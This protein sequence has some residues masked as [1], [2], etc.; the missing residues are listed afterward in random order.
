[1]GIKVR[2]D[3]LEK[4]GILAFGEVYRGSL[5]PSSLEVLT[6]LREIADKL[7]KKL[8]LLCLIGEEQS[9]KDMDLL[10]RCLAD[11]IWLIIH[12]ELEAF[13]DDLYG[14]VL[15]EVVKSVSPRG[16]F[17]PA[18]SFGCALAPRVAGV[19]GLGLCAHVNQIEVIDDKIV[20]SRPTYG[21]NIIARLIC[22]TEPVMA[23]ISV[24]VFGVREG[25]KEPEFI[26]L[27]MP[28]NFGWKSK[29][30]L[31]RVTLS[32][33]QPTFLST[34]KIVVAGGRGLKTKENFQKLFEL[35]RI[36][37]AEVGATRP[38]CYE[39][40]V[41]E[42]RMI[43]ISGVSVKPK[44]YI[45]FGISGALQHVIGMENS[46]FIVAVN[47]DKEAPLVKMAHLSL[48]G[49]A[50]KILDLMIKKLRSKKPAF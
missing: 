45:G 26:K 19:L 24:G 10:R 33:R 49:D 31:R 2:L 41:E 6:P 48:I 18:T 4:G 11:E 38:L 29:I 12:R 14:E 13:R 50:S 46:E 23:T 17:F 40:W 9:F 15:T 28:Q 34:A 44:L 30:K 43:G 1:M 5:H 42:E 22:R 27:E 7:Q 39:G 21:E 32:H 35:A 37:G 3:Q 47:I 36:L 8:V 25:Q 20:F 16:L